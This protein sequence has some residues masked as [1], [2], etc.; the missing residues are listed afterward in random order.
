[1]LYGLGSLWGVCTHTAGALFQERTASPCGMVVALLEVKVSQ[2]W[3]VILALNPSAI[4]VVP[5]CLTFYA[6]RQ[7]LIARK[8]SRGLTSTC[9][10][11]CN[12]L[13]EPLIC[14]VTHTLK[15]L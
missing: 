8:R 2:W 9:F 15:R 11:P 14:T 13:S 5:Y 4:A 1:M 10:L 12:V 6:R 7:H 3:N